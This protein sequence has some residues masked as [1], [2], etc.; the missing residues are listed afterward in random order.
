MKLSVPSFATILLLSSVMLA[1]HS[2]G[3]G[4][5]SGG[6]SSG[7]SSGGGSHGGGGGSY[8]GASSGGSSHS[9]GSSGGGS[10]YSGGGHNSSGGSHS[11]AGG[12]PSRGGPGSSGGHDSS[13]LL[14]SRQTSLVKGTATTRTIREPKG[15]LEIRT[16]PEKRTF[17]SFLRHPFR[18]PEFRTVVVFRPPVCLKGPCRVCPVAQVHSGG[19]CV[20]AT[21][22]L[23]SRNAC[24]YRGM[25]SDSACLSQ[26]LFV[27]PCSAIRMDAERQEQRLQSAQ[28]AQ[29]SACAQ[30]PSQACSEATATVE[31]EERLYQTLQDRYRQCRLGGGV[32]YSFRG[33]PHS[34][35]PGFGFDPLRLELNY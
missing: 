34:G 32:D 26:T 18:K 8:S 4:G 31:D 33:N 1:Q 12:S 13:T 35:G 19:G 24:W 11:F 15:A 7:G 17:F 27:D 10:S 29:Q 21:V 20:A 23:H 14:S 5:S 25:W 16:V 30:G 3:G 6:G 2:S 22:P 28:A 9:G